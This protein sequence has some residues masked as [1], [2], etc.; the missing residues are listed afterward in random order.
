MLQCYIAT[1]G[2]RTHLQISVGKMK[3]D[4]LKCKGVHDKAFPLQKIFIN[5]DASYSSVLERIKA[6][7]YESDDM[8]GIFELPMCP[9]RSHKHLC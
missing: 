2:F 8:E 1:V 3:Y 5:K 4:E 9:Y 7:L 6:E